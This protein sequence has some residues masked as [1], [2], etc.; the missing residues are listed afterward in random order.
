MLSVTDELLTYIIKL[1]RRYHWILLKIQPDY[2]KVEIFESLKKYLN[3][4]QS[5]IYMIQ[6]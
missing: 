4:Y 3:E 5:I 2:E 1:A 6:R